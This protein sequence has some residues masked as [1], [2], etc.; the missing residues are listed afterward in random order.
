MAGKV[1]LS[2]V[3]P[4]FNESMNIITLYDRLKKTIGQKDL[5]VEVIYVNDGSTDESLTIIQGICQSD[6]SIKYIDFSRNFGHQISI[7]AGIENSKGEHIIVMDGDGQ[8]PPEVIWELYE[9]C[10]NGFDVVYA[11]RKKRSGETKL[12]RWTAH[13]FYRLLQR[14]TKVSIP[15]DTGDFRIISRR[16]ANILCSLNEQ[17]KFI[18][19]QISWIGFNQSFIEYDR[20]ERLA[21]ETKFSYKKMIS[22]AIDGISGF[23]RWPLKIA[24]MGGFLVSIL[25][26]I[27][28][29]Y[30]LY[31]KLYG[32]TVPGWASTNIAIL[33]IGG[34]QLIGIGI[35]G[36]YLGRVSDNVKNRPTYLIKETNIEK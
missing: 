34:I 22:F 29:L 3:I 2:V 24:T 12:K 18:R 7:F 11:K 20:E 5:N 8:D 14:I 36:E 16:V 9:K 32:F 17:N 25:A 28:I 30:T 26:F 21:G 33:F 35:L 4:I 15:V 23:S 6:P 10:L 27:L 31:Q 13:M 1:Q 19:G